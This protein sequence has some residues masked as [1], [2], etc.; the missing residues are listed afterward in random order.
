MRIYVASSWRNK[1]QPKIVG[2]LLALGH[3]VYDF[4]HPPAGTAFGWSQIDAAYTGKSYAPEEA[5]RVSFMLEHPLAQAAYRSDAGAVEACDLCVMVMPCGNSA[6]LE[7][8]M[9]IGLGKKTAVLMPEAPRFEWHIPLEP[10]LMI[11]GASARFTSVAP[12]LQWVRGLKIRSPRSRARDALF[13]AGR[14]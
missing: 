4:R 12:F 5:V 2:E 9:A 11:K 1:V 13:S 10:E 7:L 8:G 6:H 3:R 14:P